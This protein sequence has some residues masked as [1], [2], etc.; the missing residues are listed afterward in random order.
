MS[1]NT[2]AV[3]LRRALTVLCLA[4]IVVMSIEGRMLQLPFISRAAAVREM[5]T[6]TDRAWPDYPGFLEGVREHT[7]PGD[8]IALILPTMSWERGY[9]YGYYRASYFLAGR[10]VL[11]LVEAGDRRLP[12]N[13]HDAKYIAVFGVRL[14]HPADVM[15]RSGRGA[16][17]RLRTR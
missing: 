3:N 17:L 9:F 12:Q 1:H 13:F 15:W 16:L 6:D 7:K 4:A 5:V 10:E 14:R 2:R 8:S 11:P